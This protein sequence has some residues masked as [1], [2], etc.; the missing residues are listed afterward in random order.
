MEVFNTSYKIIFKSFYTEF[1]SLNKKK[2]LKSLWNVLITIIITNNNY[3]IP[4]GGY[5]MLT[6]A[7]YNKLGVDFA[8]GGKPEYPEK[9]LAVRLR[10][11]NLI[12]REEN[13]RTG[14]KI[15]EVRLRSTNLIQREENRSTGRKTLRVKSRST[16]LIKR[17]ENRSTRRKT[18]G[19]RLRSTKLSPPAE[20]GS[21]SQVIVSGG[22]NDDHYANLTP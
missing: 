11:T 13:R 20:L 16:N 14:R 9:T 1:S 6:T 10:S 7:N 4:W 22:M 19:V 21:Q 2:H 3:C 15:L 17:E 5:S 8:E 18:L 12:Q